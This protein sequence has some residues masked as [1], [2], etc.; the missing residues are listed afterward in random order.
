[1]RAPSPVNAFTDEAVLAKTRRYL[2]DRIV[3]RPTRY[4]I[5]YA[6]KR[7]VRLESSQGPLECF[8]HGDPRDGRPAELLVVKFPGTAGRA[9]RASD[10]PIGMLPKM[11]TRMW[12][13]NPPGYGGSGGKAS[14]ARIAEAAIEFWNQVAQREADQHTV[15]LLCGNSLGSVTTLHVAASIDWGMRRCGLVLRNVPPLE[16]VVKRAATRYPLGWLANGIAESVCDSMNALVTAP[17]VNLPAVF[18]QSELD[19][20]VPLAMQQTVIDAYTGAKRAVLLS[21]LPHGGVA[22]TAHAVAI[23]QAI[24]W[25][26]SQITRN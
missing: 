18:L 17:R 22:T 11:R 9:E 10:F 21:G 7:P 26:W 1:M 19:T 12:A 6:P 5:D 16:A 20:L 23:E 14:L 4:P 24:D 13:W 15:I 25:L 3:L 2:L 8:V